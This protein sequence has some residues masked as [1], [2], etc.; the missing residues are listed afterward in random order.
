MAG[1]VDELLGEIG[2]KI[3]T[4]REAR[5]RFADQLAPEF[6][7]FDYLRTDEMGLSRCFAALLAPKGTHGQGSVFLQAFLEALGVSEKWPDLSHCEV[8]TERQANGM[9]RIDIFLEFPNGIIGIENKPW[10][11]DQVN[12]LADYANFLRTFSEERKKQNWLLIFLSDRDPSEESISKD[13]LLKL[14]ANGNFIHFDYAETSVWLETCAAKARNGTV[15]VF[16][17]E[18]AKFIRT[19]INGALDMSDEK[20]VS[21]AVL[22]TDNTLEAAFQVFGAMGEV[23]RTLLAQLKR[24]LSVA[25]EKKN[26]KLGFW[27]LQGFHRYATIGIHL[28]HSAQKLCL[29]FEF[30]RSNLDCLV[31][32]I[33]RTADNFQDK[34]L[35]TDVNQLM[36]E[37]FG[38]GKTNVTYPWYADLPVPRFPQEMRNWQ[39][40][41]LPWTMIKN[42]TMAEKIVDFAVEVRDAFSKRNMLCLLGD[43]AAGNPA[44]N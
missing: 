18:L 8:A 39:A 11:C 31:W 30:E 27:D 16:V 5:N 37:A 36:T 1:D 44:E 4:M 6:R 2:F 20:E 33:G 13:H 21:T 3:A 14:H 22:Q 34:R 12:Q 24:D 41:V 29:Y 19:D 17:E 10:A 26:L 23:K 25:L 38:G 42:N 32:G 43:E 15:R 40:N 9:R 28:Q 35:W 7:I